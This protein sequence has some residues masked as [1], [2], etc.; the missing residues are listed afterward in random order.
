[1]SNDE[2]R[3]LIIKAFDPIKP[4]SFFL[5]CSSSPRN[6]SSNAETTLSSPKSHSKQIVNFESSQFCK[7]PS[8][9]DN[10]HIQGYHQTNNG[11]L[12]PLQHFKSFFKQSEVFIFL[13]SDLGWTWRI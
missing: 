8:I 2:Q 5:S 7:V 10:Q 1:M 12:Y 9:P 13:I 6:L 11:I 3:L 4:F